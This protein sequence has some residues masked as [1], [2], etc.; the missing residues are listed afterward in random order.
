MT[1]PSQFGGFDDA[2]KKAGHHRGHEGPRRKNMSQVS[3]QIH[4]PGATLPPS[5]LEP[6]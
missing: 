5:A 3:P 4:N 2:A 6:I 1:Q